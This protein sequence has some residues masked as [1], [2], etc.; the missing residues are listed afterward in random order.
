ME[1]LYVA[2]GTGG[3][4]KIGLSMHPQARKVALRCEFAKRGDCLVRFEHCAP[5][6]FARG[7]EWKLQTEM[8][9]L[10]PRESGREWFLNGDFETAFALAEKLTAE[11]L[12]VDAY[13]KTP[14]G[15]RRKK[16]LA[17]YVRNQIQENA[18]NAVAVE[19]ARKKRLSEIQ[20]RRDTRQRRANGP[21]AM[22]VNYL[23]AA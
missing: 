8:G 16:R 21:M 1:H 4:L 13:D 18:A 10:F 9:L 5:V 14:A 6:V 15:V 20:A 3:L 19:A 11:R 12:V 2:Q 7:I 17:A 23:V 22:V